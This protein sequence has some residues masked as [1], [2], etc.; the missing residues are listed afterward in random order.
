MNTLSTE[1]VAGILKRLFADAEQTQGTIRQLLSDLTPAERAARMS[2]P[3]TDYREFYHRV[4]EVHM[5]VSPE[6]GTLLYML[7]R[8]TQA[9]AIIEFGTSFG[10]STIHL[11]A[12]LRDNGGGHLI[13]SDFEPTKIAQARANLEAA[14]LSDLVEIRDGDAL[15]TLAS[16][17]PNSIDLVLLDG[18]KPLYSPVLD[19]LE[20]RIRSGAFIIA[21]NADA[22]PSYVA[23]VRA[24]NGGF[25]S[26]PFGPDVEVSIKL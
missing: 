13:G 20:G 11:A 7:A 10:I 21:D 18:H 8:A 12:A 6:T 22:N 2:N 19:L 1:P 14:G 24:V 23:R 3:D 26:V 4:R 17:L 16:N 15:Q 5:P 25:M 9:R